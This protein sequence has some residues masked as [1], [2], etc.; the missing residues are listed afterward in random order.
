MGRW[1]KVEE[2]AYPCIFLA[3]DASSFMT[4][5]T[6]IVDGGPPAQLGDA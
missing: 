1:G 2:I 6:I 4:G 5:E 3:S